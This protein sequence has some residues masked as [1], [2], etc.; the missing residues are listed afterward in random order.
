MVHMCS[1]RPINVSISAWSVKVQIRIASMLANHA[2]NLWSGRET[3]RRRRSKSQPKKV[4]CSANPPSAASF[5]RA[6]SSALGIGSL[7]VRG[8]PMMC[9]ASGKAADARWGLLPSSGTTVTPSS[10]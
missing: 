3:M 6:K 4:C 10:K 2:L 7:P 9:T 1:R 8:R 5:L